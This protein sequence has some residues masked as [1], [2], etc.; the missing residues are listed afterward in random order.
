MITN[1]S[2]N[3]QTVI[4]LCHLTNS[5]SLIVSANNFTVNF[6]FHSLCF[7]LNKSRLGEAH[8][9]AQKSNGCKYHPH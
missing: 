8:K 4:I 9:N 5:T 3:S 2:I 1:L 6:H 7:M